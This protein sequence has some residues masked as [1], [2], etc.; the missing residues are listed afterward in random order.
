[1]R[2]CKYSGACKVDGPILQ[3]RVD[4]QVL[5]V[6]A[7][8]VLHVRSDVRQQCLALH[9]TVLTDLTALVKGTYKFRFWVE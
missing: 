9:A 6:V 7:A 1:M 5:E 8:A 3:M 4:V 2:K